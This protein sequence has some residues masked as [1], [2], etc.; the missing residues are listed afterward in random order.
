MTAHRAVPLAV[1]MGDPGGVGPEI[2]AHAWQAMRRNGPAFFVIADPHLFNQP[3][4][5]TK[6]IDDGQSAAGVFADALPILPLENRVAASLGQTDTANA[7]AILESIERAVAF[8]TQHGGG[9]V[10]N[11][12]QKS[13]LMSAGFT[14]PGH[15]EFLADLT[16]NTPM[17]NGL[18]RGPIMMLAGPTLKSV[19]V[20]VHASV[21]DAIGCLTATM[22][23]H[24]AHVVAQSLKYDF[25]IDEPRIAISGLNPHAGE[26]GALGME[27]EMIIAPAIENLAAAGYNV[28]GPKPADGM[29]H[30]SARAAYD[31]AICM[32]HDQA[33]IPVK[34]LAFDETVNVTLGLPVVRTSPDHG[35]ALDIAGKDIARADSLIA[36]INL[37][38]DITTRRQVK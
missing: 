18:T 33:L 20:T 10:T 14:F 28:V 22:I 11:P 8:A 15:T 9:V 23:E 38:A 2:T 35:T 37:A 27:D 16:K 34:T 19:P 24:C 4:I 7:P 26:G 17:R 31:V 5:E 30:S 25:G 6:I 1:T 32:L 29:F 21:K 12:I 13:T 3:N 36:S